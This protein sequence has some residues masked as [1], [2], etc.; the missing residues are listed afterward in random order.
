MTAGCTSADTANSRHASKSGSTS[1]RFRRSHVA[2]SKSWAVRLYSG[3]LPAVTTIQPSG[4]RM[5]AEDLVLQKLQHGRRQ[6]LRYAV[7][8][9]EEQDALAACPVASIASYTEA[10]ISLMVYSDTW[11]STPS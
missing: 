5:A 11:Y 4:T 1:M 2:M 9:V 8:L 6:R 10:M 7:D 3:G